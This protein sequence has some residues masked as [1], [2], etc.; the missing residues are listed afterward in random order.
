[1]K[2]LPG[3]MATMSVSGKRAADVARGHAPSREVDLDT[4]VSGMVAPFDL[5]IG[6][7]TA[8]HQVHV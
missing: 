8:N 7:L 2:N 1:M 5:R 4:K 3:H 6:A